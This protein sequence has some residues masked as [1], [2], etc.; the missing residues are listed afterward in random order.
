[1]AKVKQIG[2][3]QFAVT[4]D[5]TGAILKRKGRR[6][7]YPTRAEALADARET[8]RRVMRKSGR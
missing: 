5:H 6:V 3:N 4:H 7:I 1:M 8:R 2:K